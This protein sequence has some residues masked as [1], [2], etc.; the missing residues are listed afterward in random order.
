MTFY[1]TYHLANYSLCYWLVF[2]IYLFFTPLSIFP[3]STFLHNCRLCNSSL[4]LTPRYL[5]TTFLYSHSTT[6]PRIKN[7][8]SY[9]KQGTDI[10]GYNPPAV[11]SLHARQTKLPIHSIFYKHM[12][13]SVKAFTKHKLCLLLKNLTKPFM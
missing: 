1:G 11:S 3:L 2:L 8:K 4:S 10:S 5:N 13:F 9:P 12:N 7:L 6:K